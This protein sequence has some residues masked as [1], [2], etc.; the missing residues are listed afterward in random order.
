MING[1]KPK[2]AEKSW[3]VFEGIGSLSARVASSR[4]IRVPKVARTRADVLRAGGIVRVGVFS[5]RSVVEMTK[6]A[7]MLPHARRLMGAITAGLDSLMGDNGR[8]RGWSVNTRIT[9]RKE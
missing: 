7:M 4:A 9:K 8:A 3:G 1:K 5:G 2:R 6:P